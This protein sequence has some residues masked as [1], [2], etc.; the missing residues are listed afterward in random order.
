[1]PPDD[2]HDWISIEDPDYE[3]TWLFDATFLRSNWVCIYGRG[4]QGIL[5]EPAPHLAQGCCSMGAW[6]T[7]EDDRARVDRA[8]ARLTDADWQHRRE[9]AGRWWRGRGKDDV[10][11]R[12]VD[13]ACIFLNRPGFETGPGC[14]L[15]LGALRVGEPPHTWKPNVCWQLPLRI[16]ELTDSDGH[17]TT[18]VREWKRRDWGDGGAEFAWWCTES[19]DAFA[20]NRPVYQSLKPELIEL[21][22]EKV[23]RLLVR[24]LEGPQLLP[25]PALRGRKPRVMP[26]EGPPPVV[27]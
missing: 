23:Y 12:L 20:G 3:R 25:H 1:M 16:D 19:P 26:E 5:T 24:R 9:G 11:T 22:G 15:H 8:A 21:I 27:G 13:R 4:C 7:D 14:A 6:F 18:M 10:S 2:G 17:I